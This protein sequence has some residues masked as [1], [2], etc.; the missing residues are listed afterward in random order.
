MGQC[1]S[2]HVLGMSWDVLVLSTGAALGVRGVGFQWAFALSIRD[3]LDTGRDLK[4]KKKPGECQR[5]RDVQK[6][7]M[8]KES[9]NAKD[10]RAW[11][12]VALLQAVT[13]S[14][15]NKRIE[16]KKRVKTAVGTVVPLH[17]FCMPN[18]DRH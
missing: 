1:L 18:F 11:P 12:A 16:G 3:K 17:V 15:G 13:T 7:E 2:L 8:C 6:K 14:P 4:K 5:G 9:A 10:G